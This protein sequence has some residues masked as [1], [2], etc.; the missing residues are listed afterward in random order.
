MS[1]EM[2]TTARPRC[3]LCGA[4]A[5]V[6]CQA[7][8]AFLC[9]PC[10]AEVHGANL[11]ASRHRRT[12][13]PPRNDARVSARRMGL[14][15]AG[16]ARL[17]PAAANDVRA[18]CGSTLQVWARRMG[19]DAGAAC[20]CAAAAGRTVWVDFAAVAPRIP[21]RVAM[22]ASLWREVAAHAAG[23]EPGYALQ[24]LVAQT[25]RRVCLWRR[26]R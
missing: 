6:H 21:L 9:A 23:H 13:I 10:D 26:R 17:R 24:R 7:D 1:A 11:L 20:V 8:A 2:R 3:A 16:A 19:L 14:E 12:R 18:R 4:R 25:C 5:D 15:D 22:A